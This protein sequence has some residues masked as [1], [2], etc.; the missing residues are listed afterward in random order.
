MFVLALFSR[1][2]QRRGYDNEDKPLGFGYRMVGGRWWSGGVSGV[3]GAAFET[4]NAMRWLKLKL[5]FV[6]E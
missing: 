4:R 2:S 3:V 1:R 6:D 5:P